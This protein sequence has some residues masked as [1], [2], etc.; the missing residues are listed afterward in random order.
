MKSKKIRF[1]ILDF[2]VIFSVVL[3]IFSAVLQGLAVNKF[4]DS[5]T[6]ED[7]IITLKLKNV[8]ESIFNE[9]RKGDHIFSNELFGNESVGVV[10]KKMKHSSSQKIIEDGYEDSEIVEYEIQI[11]SLCIRSSKGFCSFNDNLIVPGMFF[12]ADNGYVG[13]DC[14]IVSVKPAD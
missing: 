13:F 11:L 6:I 1:N 8:D 14:E 7:T 2:I 5:N 12:S 3:I 4:E 9:I 10:S